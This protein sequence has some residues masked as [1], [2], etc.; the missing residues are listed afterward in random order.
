MPNFCAKTFLNL[1][2][3]QQTDDIA[4]SST[5]PCALLKDIIAKSGLRLSLEKSSSQQFVVFV[6]WP[7]TSW[8]FCGTIVLLY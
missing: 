6:K 7:F 2:F 3:H 8:Q 5:L 4:Q 1:Q